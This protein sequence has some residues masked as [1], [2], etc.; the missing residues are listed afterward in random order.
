MSQFGTFMMRLFWSVGGRVLCG[1]HAT[2]GGG[3]SQK[4]EAAGEA[5]E[6]EPRQREGADRHAIRSVM[7]FTR[8]GLD[9]T[10]AHGEGHERVERGGG[11]QQSHRRAVGATTDLRRPCPSLRT[12]AA[13][14]QSTHVSTPTSAV[15]HSRV[16]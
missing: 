1:D 2:G 7:G 6:D 5:C 15:R 4:D 8:Y 14:I 13:L 10:D 12:D 3:H 16:G 11:Q 9:A